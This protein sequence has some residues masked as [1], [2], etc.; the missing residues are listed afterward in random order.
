VYLPSVANHSL[1]LSGSYQQEDLSNIIFS[2]RFFNARG[3][4]ESDSARMWR[5]S[6]NYHFPVAY[7]DWGFG[8]IVYFQRVRTN[9]FYDFSQLYSGSKDRKANVR[10]TGVELFFDTKWW[11]QLPVS[12]GVRYSYLLD[13]AASGIKQHQLELILPTDLLSN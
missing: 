9:L 11:N 1:V 12:F 3:Y 7:P 2:N 6:V 13:A 8:G 10:S 5:A 4:D